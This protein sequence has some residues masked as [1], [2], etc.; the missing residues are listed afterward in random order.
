MTFLLGIVC[1]KNIQT[2]THGFLWP[3][4]RTKLNT[5]KDKTLTTSGTKANE[6]PIE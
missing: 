4:I 2:L 6:S 1:T 5:L 3:E